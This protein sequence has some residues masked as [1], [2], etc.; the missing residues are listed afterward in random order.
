MLVGEGEYNINNIKE[1]KVT[2]SFLGL[3]EED[4]KC[5]NED[6][7]QDCTTKLYLDT[8]MGECGCVPLNIKLS[9][10]VQLV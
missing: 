7:L 3:D 10:Q 9:H 5:Q 8:I 6:T 4:R 2:E 1:L